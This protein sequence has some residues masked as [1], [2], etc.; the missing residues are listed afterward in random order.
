MRLCLLAAGL[1]W[2]T[3]AASAGA[4]P[5]APGLGTVGGQVLGPN[6]KAV[7]GARVTLQSSEGRNPQTT[8]TNAQGHF[9]FPSL[10][11]GLYDL[12]AYSN[13]RLSEW[14]HNVWVNRGKQTNV[15][16]RLRPKKPAL[17]NRS[18]SSTKP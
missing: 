7:D 1:L 2:A 16:L 9:W 11:S 14:R 17:S 4:A 12:R 6:G 15:T 10:P 8:E 5:Q 3:L 18:P 13:G